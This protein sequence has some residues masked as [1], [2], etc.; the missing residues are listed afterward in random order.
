MP[1]FIRALAVCLACVVVSV[2]A[3]AFAAEPPWP[4][5]SYAY[6]ADDEPLPEVLR[7]F[8]RS[9]G[10]NTSISPKVQGI[11]SGRFFAETP[12]DFLNRLANAYGFTWYYHGGVLYVHAISETV[13]RSIEVTPEDIPDLRNALRGLGVVDDRFGWGE[14][15]DRGV[16]I[17]SGPPS[18]VSLVEQTIRLLPS[19][20]SRGITISVFRLEHAS[21]DDR[22][23]F[24][25]DRQVTVPGVATILRNLVTATQNTVGTRNEPIRTAPIPLVSDLM[26]GNG[27]PSLTIQSGQIESGNATTRPA[28]AESAAPRRVDAPTESPVIQADTRLNAVIIKDQAERM[29]SYEKLIRVLDVPTALIEIE[30]A[31]VDVNVSQIAE[32]GIR[33]QGR[34]GNVAGGFGTINSPL[35]SDTAVSVGVGNNPNLQTILTGTGDF[36]LTKISALESTGDA[37]ILSRPSV[38]TLDNMEA[39][40]DLSETFY[41]RVEGERVA[42]V[43]PVSA[44]VMLKVTPRLIRQGGENRI[45]LTVDIEDGN[46]QRDEPVSELPTVR[47]STIST[48]AVVREQQ[49]LLIGGYYLEA[50]VKNNDRIPIL[51]DIPLLGF[52]FKRTSTEAQKRERMFMITPRLVQVPS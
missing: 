43:V 14:F 8:G 51:G 25:R 44:G 26:L 41:I 32:L 6:R 49:S 52:L 9:F 36:L 37:S 22:V 33:W 18:Y 10:V 39:V 11:V 46:I 35:P 1:R 45:Q 13:S 16:V 48:Q 42:D 19:T 50:D 40:L 27:L 31:V 20:P 2:A 21:A 24:Y 47:R 4:A 7:A 34:S 38:L 15:P 23:F 17:V 3:V 28:S 29:P 30:A 12:S 5:A